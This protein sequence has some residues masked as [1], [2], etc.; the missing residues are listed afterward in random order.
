MKIDT[1][2]QSC[3]C[4][5]SASSRLIC[6]G[7]DFEYDSCENLFKYHECLDCG[8]IFLI[9]LPDRKELL[10]IYPSNYANYSQKRNQSL[11]FKV[12]FLLDKLSL[13]K[14]KS[15]V[16]SVYAILDIGCADG[17]TL[18]CLKKIFTGTSILKG[19]EISSIA[20]N[21]SRLKGYEVVVGNIESIDLENDGF[22]LVIMQQVIEHLYKPDRALEK[23]SNALSHGGILVIETPTREC[24]D[25]KIFNNKYWG[26]YHIP[27][28][29]NIFSAKGLKEIASKYYLEIANV[30][31]KPQPV[32]WI[33]S[34]HHYLKDNG[35][36]KIIYEFF[37]MKNVVLLAFFTF[38][39]ILQ[40]VFT[41][42]MSNM[43]VIFKKI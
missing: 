28:H 6:V 3:T 35:F 15:Y 18:D 1:F 39:E 19:V 5:G 33:W 25:R 2:Q 34:I 11:A 17:L 13:R 14:L 24:L 42:R 8:H 23:I 10:K 30:C 16:E 7:K 40:F 4:C 12:K 22:D 38:L 31:Y 29:F 36:S 20:A 9:N 27:R 26:G 43:Q 21:Y 32:H 41:K 37:N